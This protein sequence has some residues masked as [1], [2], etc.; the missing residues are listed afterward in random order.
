MQ[1]ILYLLA[2]ETISNPLRFSVFSEV[3]QHRIPKCISL[4][5]ILCCGQTKL[6]EYFSVLLRF[7]VVFVRFSDRQ[8]P[9]ETFRVTVQFPV[10]LQGPWSS[11]FPVFLQICTT[12][13]YT[14]LEGNR[15]QSLTGERNDWQ[16]CSSYLPQLSYF[17]LHLIVAPSPSSSLSFFS[18]LYS[19]P[20]VSSLFSAYSHLTPISR[21]LSLGLYCPSWAIYQ[22]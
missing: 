3:F 4:I 18:P 11:Q 8:F 7:S 16:L 15:E 1:H 21:I 14:G 20:L 19:S 6:C 2:E 5:R 9:V 17:F 13:L 22:E 12:L 10:A